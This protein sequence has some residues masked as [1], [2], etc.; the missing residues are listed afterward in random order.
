MLLTLSTEGHCTHQLKLIVHS[1]SHLQSPILNSCTS[2]RY[3]CTEQNLKRKYMY[4]TCTST[5][6][7]YMH[8][9]QVPI[10]LRNGDTKPA[11][12]HQS[13]PNWSTARAQ[14]KLRKFESE[15]GV[16]GVLCV[17]HATA[18]K[19]LTTRSWHFKVTVTRLSL[20]HISEPTRPY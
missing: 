6:S 4:S 18:S 19:T 16:D 1:Y 12:A 15:D 17:L 10:R 20:I 14:S 7:F 2:H 13:P 5:S 11:S 9:S 8:T 3:M